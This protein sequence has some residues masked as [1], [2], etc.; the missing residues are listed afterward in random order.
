MSTIYFTNKTV[1]KHLPFHTVAQAPPDSGY[2][3]YIV[4]NRTIKQ[5]QIF[6]L[7]DEPL[8]L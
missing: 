4:R 1:L 7:Q 8:M 2:Q 3:A 5:L 6:I